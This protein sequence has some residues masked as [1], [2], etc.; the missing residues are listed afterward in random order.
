[1]LKIFGKLPVLLAAVLMSVM[2]SSSLMAAFG[3]DFLDAL[4]ALEDGDYQKAIGKLEKAIKGKDD[5]GLDQRF[6]GL[7]YGNYIPYYYLG[8]ARYKLGDCRGA[9]EAWNESAKQGVVTGLKEYSTLQ[10]GVTACSGEVVDIPKLAA[11]AKQAIDSVSSRSGQLQALSSDFRELG[12]NALYQREWVSRWEPVLKS[13]SQSVGDME[14]RLSAAASAKDDK[15][16]QV[17]KS[18]ATTLAGT[19]VSSMTQATNQIA[20]IRQQQAGQVVEARKRARR[21]LMQAVA[22]ARAQE[23]VNANAQIS[24]SYTSLMDQADRGEGLSADTPA[25]I[26]LQQVQSINTAIRRYKVAIQDW[27]RTEENIAHRTPPADL[28]QI[29]IEYLAGNYENT[30]QMVDPGSF[31]DDRARIQAL[32]FR[33]AASYRLFMLS[34]EKDT[35][36]L[37]QAQSDIREIKSLRKDFSPYIP[38]FS[39]KFLDLFRRSS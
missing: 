39:P 14:S 31:S 6:Y 29:V 35:Q 30:I 13:A 24:Q 8:Q 21:E 32:L 22:S 4:D 38:A 18:E 27:R 34:G 16:I 12:S 15:A 17:I 33:A 10:A 19:L 5:A 11:E 28:K 3:T 9:I 25:S 20:A 23:T 7:V 37:Q 1:M 36:N 2:L 26:Q